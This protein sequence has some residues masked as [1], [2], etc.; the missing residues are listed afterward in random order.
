MSADPRRPRHRGSVH[1][2]RATGSGLGSGDKIEVA[3]LNSDGSLDTSFDDDGLATIDLHPSRV[4][5]ANDVALLPDGRIVLA[6]SSDT[7]SGFNADIA[8]VRLNANG[9][10]D[11][12]FGNNGIVPASF[13]NANETAGDLVLQSNGK[14][15]VVGQSYPNTNDF[16]ILVARYNADGSVDSAAADWRPSLAAVG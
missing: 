9:S 3:R 15:V 7:G 8:L 4:D 12:T 16:N 6:G 13:A 14:I 1:A 5:L 2:Q 11:T 10:L